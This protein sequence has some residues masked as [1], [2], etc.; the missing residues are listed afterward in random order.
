MQTPRRAGTHAES[1][2]ARST[3]PP[4]PRAESA[5]SPAPALGPSRSPGCAHVEATAGRSLRIVLDAQARLLE[6]ASVLLVGE[7]AELLALGEVT[8]SRRLP[9]HEVVIDH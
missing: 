8:N 1:R 2:S 5:R 6:G 3:M 4:D 9:H 7:D